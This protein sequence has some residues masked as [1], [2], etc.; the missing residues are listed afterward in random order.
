MINGKIKAKELELSAWLTEQLK[1]KVKARNLSQDG[2]HRIMDNQMDN[3]LELAKSMVSELIQDH[4]DLALPME[5]PSFQGCT[6]RILFGNLGAVPVVFKCFV[7]ADR[8]HH[9][10]RMLQ[11][12]AP[13][14]TVPHL[15]P[16]ETDFIL[17]MERLPGEALHAR[18]PT[19]GANEKQEIFRQMG[20][21]FAR[22]SRS[23]QGNAAAAP[24][25]GL[26]PGIDLDFYRVTD[27]PTFYD[28]VV[29]TGLQ[30]LAEHDIPQHELL[31]NTLRQLKCIRDE[32]LSFPP[33]VHQDDVHL[34]NLIVEGTDFRGFVDL[35]MCR[36][37]NEVLLLAAALTMCLPTPSLWPSLRSGYEATR[38]IALDPE[39]MALIRQT[40]TFSQ[41]IRFAWYWGTD[42]LPQWA[43]AD[44]MR[45]AIVR[46]IVKTVNLTNDMLD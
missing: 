33:F 19:L 20:S 35:E 34:N 7:T 9:E 5:M 3:Q 15:Y 12:M 4:P 16:I 6:N 10:K 45:S 44:N 25:I 14:G 42:E 28:Y 22:V 43:I 30:A 27:L 18:L 31:T 40:T 32:V 2:L 26:K 17:V 13:S 21:A 41:L 37:G 29:E 39:M 38:G 36:Q 24:Y 8:K 23:P 1:G 11:L 46:H